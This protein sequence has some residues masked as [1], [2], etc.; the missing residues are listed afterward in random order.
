M[1]YFNFN[2]NNHRFV[3]NDKPSSAPKPEPKGT[4]VPEVSLKDV[5]EVQE[6]YLKFTDEYIQSFL[7]K[8]LKK[9]K[10]IQKKVLDKVGGA[11]GLFKNMADNLYSAL[12]SMG[13]KLDDEEKKDIEALIQAYQKIAKKSS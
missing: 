9:D 1:Q 12:D 2:I 13:V 10:D 5:R 3:Y 11:K 4:E 7:T 6:N 8:F